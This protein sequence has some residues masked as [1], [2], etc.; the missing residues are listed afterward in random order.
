MELK[1]SLLFLLIFVVVV[2]LLPELRIETVI[3]AIETG[4][5]TTRHTL[6]MQPSGETEQA[7]AEPSNEFPVN[8]YHSFFTLRN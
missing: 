2:V 6:D 8:L 3:S 1:G 5:H 4:K 7:V